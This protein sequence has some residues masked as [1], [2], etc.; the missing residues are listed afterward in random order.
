MVTH[1]FRGTALR[2]HCATFAAIGAIGVLAL[3]AACEKMPLLAPTGTVISLFPTATNVALNSEIEIVATLIEQGVAQTPGTGTGTGATGT[4]S[5]G[6]P[7]HNG[8]L[9]TFTSTVGRVE[10]R[11]ARTQNGQVRVKFI[12]GG[13]SGTARITAY[14]GGAVATLDNLLI[15]T[16]AAGRITVTATQQTLGSAGGSTEVLAR[17]ENEG[18]TPLP[19]VP[20]TFTTTAGT[21]NP[22]SAVT[23]E[24]GIARTTLST[25]TQAV[26][27]ARAGAQTGDVT[28]G[29]TAPLGLSLTVSPNPASAG[30]PTI[31]TINLANGAVGRDA[32]ITF[33]DGSQQ[34]LGTLSG[35]TTVTH[36]YSSPN[37]YT[38]TV[39]A[40][41]AGGSRQSQSTAVIVGAL[42]VTITAS[43]STPLVG[44]SVTFTANTGATSVPVQR[45]R[46]TYDDG[47]V[48]ETTGNSTSRT[49]DSRGT[50]T[51]R[52]DVIGVNG[53]Q[54][55]TATTQIS[56]I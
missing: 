38:A 16:A 1:S 30:V 7:V 21:V 43:S 17:V 45:Y 20:V 6:T 47:T 2:R 24:N 49:F 53:Q 34:S 11:E 3:A 31:F 50:K 48:Q 35:S 44:N 32:V 4:P 22:T 8:T 23:D 25:S 15:G 10:P 55:G 51:V 14:S 39:S 54:I 36:I 5:A 37:T 40:T 19:G 12:A 52:V 42:G 28:V 18:G 41:D 27:T 29:V 13:Q 9:V 33:G 26:V 46:W 56:V